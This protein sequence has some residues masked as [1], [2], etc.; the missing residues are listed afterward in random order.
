MWPQVKN[1]TSAPYL[2]GFTDAILLRGRNK[3]LDIA[4]SPFSSVIPPDVW[5]NRVLD[6]CSI[7]AQKSEQLVLGEKG[8]LG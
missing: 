6:T 3:V 1:Y 4:D 7:R 8:T 2:D 5:R